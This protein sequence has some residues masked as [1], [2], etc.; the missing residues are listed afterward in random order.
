MLVGTAL[1]LAVLEVA[2]AAPASADGAGPTNFESVVDR[3]DPSGA[4][5]QVEVVGG[6]SFLQVTARKGAVVEIEGYDREPYLRIEADGTVRRNARSAATYLNQSRDGTGVDLPEEVGAAGAPRW[7]TIGSDGTA[8]WH[9]HR[10][11][12]MVDATPAVGPDGVVQEWTVPLTVD[13]QEVTVSG[14]L[15][16]HPDELPWGALVGAVVGVAALLLARRIALR[17]PLLAA[18][19]VVALGLS[20]ATHAANPP[21]SGASLVPILLPA[22]ALLLALVS[23]VAPLSLRQLVLPLGAVAALAGWGVAR[24]GVLW[25]PVVPSEVPGWVERAGTGAV[26]GVAIGVAVAILLRPVDARTPSAPLPS[27][28]QISG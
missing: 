1:L 8:A 9:D 18:A 20:I 12:W 11:H 23:Y 26:L 27:G 19:S 5:V 28:G 24:V 4:P 3:V 16:R 15:L 13:G 22:A 6:D 2:G 14:R 10:I 17:V 21:E 25:M 7:V